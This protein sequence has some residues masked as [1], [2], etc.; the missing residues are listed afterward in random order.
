MKNKPDC[1]TCVHKGTDFY[2]GLCPQNDAELLPQEENNCY[3]YKPKESL[4][5]Q[6]NNQS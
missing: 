3:Y 6:R 1:R 2:G 5:E 4:R